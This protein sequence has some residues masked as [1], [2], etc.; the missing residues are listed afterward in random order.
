[1]NRSMIHWLSDSKEIPQEMVILLA[2]PG[3]GNVGKVLV[4]AIIG[5]IVAVVICASDNRPPTH[6]RDTLL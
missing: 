5:C 4:D 6:K 3:V 1:M 2:L